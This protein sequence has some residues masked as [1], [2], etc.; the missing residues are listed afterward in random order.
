MRIASSAQAIF[1]KKSQ[2][3]AAVV[4]APDVSIPMAGS[5]GGREASAR[6]VVTISKPE[7]VGATIALPI[8]VADMPAA[9]PPKAAE[10]NCGI[11]RPVGHAAPAHYVLHPPVIGRRRWAPHASS[12][13]PR[14]RNRAAA[15]RSRATVGVRQ[16]SAQSVRMQAALMKCQ[17]RRDAG[18]HWQSSRR[19]CRPP[20][21]TRCARLPEQT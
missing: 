15:L 19:C 5:G 11:R 1:G 14:R 10:P 8:A 18:M 21:S 17:R 3:A 4:R 2:A 16:A 13:S 20:R 12:A 6:I 9:A 7:P